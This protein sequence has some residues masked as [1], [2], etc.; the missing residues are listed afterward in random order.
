LE[1]MPS[2]LEELGGIDLWSVFFMVP[3]GRADLEEVPSAEQM[4]AAF[5]ILYNGASGASFAVKA[6]EAPHYR[7]FALQQKDKAGRPPMAGVNDGNGVLFIDHTGE[8]FPS[9]FLPLTSGNVRT[10]RLRDI[11]REAPLFKDLRDPDKLDG[12]CGLC[13]FRKVCGGSRA[14]SYNML[15]DPLAPEP[16]CLYI[17]PKAQKA[18]EG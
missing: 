13:D 7:R 17:S 10:Q 5:Q 8:V 2:L 16:C 15:G 11:Y 12:K 4:E 18:S 6:T 3:V 9:G 14:R 1:E